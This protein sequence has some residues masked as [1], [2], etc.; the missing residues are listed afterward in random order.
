MGGDVC[1][2]GQSYHNHISL[3]IEQTMPARVLMTSRQTETAI[4]SETEEGR[5]YSL[6]SSG[7]RTEG[8]LHVH[9]QQKPTLARKCELLCQGWRGGGGV[10]W[11][12]GRESSS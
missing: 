2:F 7:S 4:M 6:M 5:R 10:T 11:L 1:C 3:C 12:R 9:V 8:S